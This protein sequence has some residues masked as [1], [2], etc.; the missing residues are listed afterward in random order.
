MCRGL[1][2]AIRRFSSSL[3]L[4]LLH[5]STVGTI[6]TKEYRMYFEHNNLTVSPWHDIP[7]FPKP[8]ASLKGH[9]PAHVSD[10]V[11]FVCEIPRGTTEKMEI[12][13]AEDYNPIKQDV[14]NGKLRVFKYKDGRMPFNYGALPQTW[15]DPNNVDPHTGFKGDSDPL[16]C[17]EIADQPLAR[18]AVI[19]VRPVGILALIDEGETDWK[20]IS[21]R[22]EH[23][24]AKSIRDAKDLESAFPGL[25]DTVVDWF[26]MYKTADGKPENVFGLDAK[27]Q[28]AAFAKKIIE[29]NHSFWRRRFSL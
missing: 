9:S 1:V 23:P 3:S 4:P 17:L 13:T 6:G 2:V 22:K 18:G 24:L 5:V 26:K 28:S 15:E 21:L 16:D 11:R 7:L 10:V 14:K 19:D 29:D 8:E 12:S 25:A 27:I 20:V